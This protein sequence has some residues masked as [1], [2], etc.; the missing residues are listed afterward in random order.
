MT[1][2]EWVELIA[3]HLRAARMFESGRLRVETKFRLAYGHEITGY[4]SDGMPQAYPVKYQ[5]D[6]AIIE[7][8]KGGTTFPR[9]IVE[10]KINSVST[11]DVITYSTKAAAHR[12]VHPY[13]R[14]GIMLG[15]RGNHALPGRLFHHG[16]EF[17]FKVSFRAFRP[18]A[19]ELSRFV[20][21]L[22]YERAAPFHGNA[23][24]TRASV[25]T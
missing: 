17:D 5:T 20:A 8:A 4:G 19:L 15:K 25:G 13:L 18:Q 23:S 16:G 22:Q 12:S 24:E 6:L 14:Y 3:K 11:H 1:E 2:V 9:V 7:S 21:L 10:A